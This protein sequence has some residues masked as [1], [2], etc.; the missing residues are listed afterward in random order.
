MVSWIKKSKIDGID[1]DDAG[2]TSAGLQKPF[3]L[4]GQLKQQRATL[5][6]KMQLNT[7]NDIAAI[8]GEISEGNLAII[9]VTG[10]I[11][12][13]EFSILELR[14]AIEQIRGTCKQLGGAIARLGDRYLVATPNQALQL[15]V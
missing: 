14:R 7:I 4:A 13:G 6:K 3:D 12:S 2:S 10:F 9:D 11:T 8:Q 1:D 5:V 15:I